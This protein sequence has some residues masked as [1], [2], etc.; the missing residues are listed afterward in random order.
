MRSV[1]TRYGLARLP[2]RGNLRAPVARR[3]FVRLATVRAMSRSATGSPATI[4][5]AVAG[6]DTVQ[7]LDLSFRLRAEAALAAFDCGPG[8]RVLD[9]GCG[10]GS[11]SGLLAA[12][13]RVTCVDVSEENIESVRRR[14]PDMEAVQADTTALPF[15]ASSFDAAVF[16]EVL[17]HVEDDRGA[18]AE[19][20]RVVRAD[21]L[22]ILTV[23]NLAAPAP[24]LERLPLRSNHAR[25]GPERHVR[26]GYSPE[27]LTRLLRDSGF[28]I[29]AMTSLGGIAYR[30]TADL[31]SAVHLAYRSLRRQPSWTW[32]DVEADR[33]NAFVRAYGALFPALLALARLGA[34]TQGMHGATL[35]V[36]AR[37][38]AR[39]SGFA[40]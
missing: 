12:S 8:A 15:A 10:V 19:L 27:Q 4:R 24:L 28:G 1:A 7:A 11:F 13:H 34:G 5:R 9:V 2:G 17:E 16:M 40:P 6:T 14:H 37:V 29:E 21:G 30:L 32:A 31:V 3:P 23:P 33:G 20:G 39:R 25:P 35:L 26:D 18:L 38:L 22:L 36:K